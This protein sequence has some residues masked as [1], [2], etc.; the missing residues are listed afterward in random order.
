MNGREV[1]ALLDTG[2]CRSVISKSFANYVWARVKPLKPNGLSVLATAD[3]HMVRVL[4]TTK[5][6]VDLSSDIMKYEFYVLEK[7][8]QNVILGLDFLEANSATM[9]C[10]NKTIS[11]FNTVVMDYKREAS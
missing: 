5:L 6:D 4:G 8:S 7:L 3:G 2:A 10:K 9:D 11:F 1:Q